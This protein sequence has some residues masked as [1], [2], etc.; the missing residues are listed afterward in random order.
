MKDENERRVVQERVVQTPQGAAT[1]VV[2]ERTSVMPTLAERATG[3]L[4]R[5]QQVVWLLFGILSGL[6][7]IRTILIALGADMKVG[8][9]MLVHGVT[10]PF[11]LPFL[12]LFGEQAKAT[13]RAPAIELG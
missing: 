11:D 5:A 7:A 4:D 9:G 10:Q 13:G 6:I 3:N 8:F 2:A 12:L 1:T